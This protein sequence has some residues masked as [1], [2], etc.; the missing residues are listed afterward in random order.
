MLKGGPRPDRT[1]EKLLAAFVDSG[2]TGPIA[3]SPSRGIDPSAGG[4]ACCE[5]EAARQQSRLQQSMLR[6]VSFSKL[7]EVESWQ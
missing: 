6:T 5:I 7:L 3:I 2:S 4:L 1:A